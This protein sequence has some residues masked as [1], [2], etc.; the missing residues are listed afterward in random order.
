[1]PTENIHLVTLETGGNQATIFSTNK[2]R[3][4]VGASELIYRVGTEYIE[5]AIQKTTGR[6]FKVK[7]VRE[8]I[9]IENTEGRHIEVALA[10]SGKALLLVRGE[11]AAK[12]FIREWSRIVV[13][14]A[15]GIDAYAAY[16]AIPLDLS[17]PLDEKIEGSFINVY[18]DAAKRY[19]LGKM[20]LPSPLARFQRIPV[21]AEC[22]YSGR[23]A[24]E[25]YGPEDDPVSS[26]AA[27]Q[28]GVSRGKK[29][30]VQRFKARIK[31]LY[32]DGKGDFIDDEN[33][34][35]IFDDDKDIRWLAVVHAD[36]NGLGELF[37]NFH[38]YLGANA[39]GR[40]YVDRYRNFCS[41]LDKISREAFKKTVGEMW[42]DE[43]YAKIVPIVV[44]GDDLTAVMDGE[45]A[46]GFAKSF[47]R[48]FSNQTAEHEDMREILNIA[49][50][51]RIGMCAGAAIIKPH[52]P[53]AQ[54]YDL[55]EELTK[56]A[57]QVKKY[58]GSDSIA[59]DFH[60]LY[61]SVAT[62][63]RDIRAKLVIEDSD[64]KKRQLTAKPYV[65]NKGEAT[66]DENISEQEK[67]DW[68]K[69]HD[70]NRFKKA[71]KAL[72]TKSDQKPLLP[73]SQSHAVREDL[74]AE[75]RETQEAEWKYLLGKYEKFAVLWRKVTGNDTPYDDALYI[76]AK[77]SEDA[78]DHRTYFLDALEAVKFA[79]AGN[80]KTTKM[81]ET[82]GDAHE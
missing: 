82:E 21:V 29:E 22:Q 13:E 48:E 38:K 40:D 16:S 59:L 45:K 14:E 15:P 53:F 47:M 28:V 32:P 66:T 70:I 17:L 19:S 50:F 6:N 23:P 24:S 10:T 27:A 25:L 73:S 43:K 62:S 79:S 77:I 35:D 31:E 60:I 56:N 41:A 7:D 5:R 2:L 8:E 76:E 26:V 72:G 55:A 34:L 39:T 36:G 67:N 4:I 74:F 33:G 75:F 30:D 54:A 3:N 11:D 69:I 57:K 18:S 81:P 37:I 63:I 1:M 46:I 44:G 80:K 68:L 78:P 12:E 64:K 58:S 51:S 71:V 20:E 52:F 61:D 9:S 49:G 42:P 65:L